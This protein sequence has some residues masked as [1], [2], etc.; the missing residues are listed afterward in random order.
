MFIKV[1]KWFSIVA[2][3][4]AALLDP[5]GANRA[6]L[7]CV[8]FTGA[9]IVLVQAVRARESLWIFGFIATAV[10]FNPL[11]PIPLPGMAF[12]WLQ[13]LCIGMFLVSLVF[14]KAPPLRSIPSITART[15]GRESL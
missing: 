1:T 8:V 12:R 14:L 15:A 3:V 4:V 2:L 10:L 7:E 6:L 5:A 9:M 11:I 13:A